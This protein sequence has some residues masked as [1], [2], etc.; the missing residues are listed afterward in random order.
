VILSAGLS[1]ACPSQRSADCVKYEVAESLNREPWFETV[2]IVMTEATGVN[3]NLPFRNS[4]TAYFPSNADSLV[5]DLSSNESLT[6]AYVAP[7]LYRGTGPEE[8]EPVWLKD[9]W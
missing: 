5:L 8:T 6:Q 4:L 7:Q 9:A 2:R 1:T 3:S